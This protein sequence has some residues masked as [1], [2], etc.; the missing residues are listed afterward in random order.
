[1]RIFTESVLFESDD[2]RQQQR[3][4]ISDGRACGAYATSLHTA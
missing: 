3:D 1:M 4:G 2:T